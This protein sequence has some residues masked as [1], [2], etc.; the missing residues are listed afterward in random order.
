M[1]TTA[2]IGFEVAVALATASPRGQGS[3]DRAVA[4]NGAVVVCDGVGSYPRSG[5]VA[6]L[7]CRLA[8]AH[9]REPGGA[10]G[11]LDLPDVLDA[12]MTDGGIGATTLLALAADGFGDLAYCL[13]GNGMVVE[14]QALAIDDEHVRMSFTELALP[15]IS[16]VG[17]RPVLGAFLPWTGTGPLPSCTGTRHLTSDRTRLFLACTDG[18]GSDEERPVGQGP[19]GTLWRQV[20][21]AIAG[22]LDA[23]GEEWDALAAC[24]DPALRLERILGTVLD[25]LVDDGS[26]DDD[27]T[28]GA[29]L[30]RPDAS[31]TLP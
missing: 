16:V 13:L 1:S 8:E 15:Q 5:E 4:C 18:I 22:L 23:I 17:G 6:E 9:L 7:A 19:D 20:D 14:A 12:S 25:R 21:P 27:A 31:R 26:L 3:Q 30:V 10:R 2:G 28:V 29:L 24:P 11:V